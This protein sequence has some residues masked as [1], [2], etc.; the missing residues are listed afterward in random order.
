M[1]GGCSDNGQDQA[2]SKIQSVV[3][4][5]QAQTLLASSESGLVAA[6]LLN[7]PDVIL[8]SQQYKNY[9]SF[10]INL[11]IIQSVPDEAIRPKQL[12]CSIICLP[13]NH[14]WRLMR[15]CSA[16]N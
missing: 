8:R 5:Q 12:S 7:A 15:P 2:L 9:F 6:W 11:V 4:F 14:L 3:W 1:K 10:C 16:R 13:L